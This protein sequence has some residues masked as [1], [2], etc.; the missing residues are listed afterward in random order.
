MTELTPTCGRLRLILGGT[1]DPLHWGHLRP[2]LNALSWLQADELRL[3]P[4][5]QPPHRDYPG[6]TAEQ[7]LK[8]TE[9]ATAEFPHVYADDWEL[10]QNRPS[11]TVQTLEELKQ[12]W[13]QDTLVFLLG[14]DAIAKL[15]GWYQWQDLLNHAHFAILSR[16]DQAPTWQPE[17][18]DFFANRWLTSPRELRRSAH[19]CAIRVANE[20]YP[21]AATT[22]RHRIQQQL[23]WESLV[24]P[25]VAAFI[26]TEGLYR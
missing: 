21:I 5:A 10:R 12:R 17:V 7:R 3:L 4:S 22:V 20:T 24:P 23:P 19:G 26:Q 15:N 9:L 2:A 1:F 11:Y 25:A 18:T 8:M 6:A 14:E 13:P 16:P